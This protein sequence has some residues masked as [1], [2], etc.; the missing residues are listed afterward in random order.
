[1]EVYVT[2]LFENGYELSLTDLAKE[3]SNDSNDPEFITRVMVDHFVPKGLNT[4]TDYDI[5]TDILKWE[6]PQNYY[7]NGFWNL[8]WDSAPYQCL[9][10]LVHICRMP[11][12]HLK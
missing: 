4:A 9:L 7:D 8:D 1:M 2:Y 5:A 3:L 11:E 10:L 6:V 12:F